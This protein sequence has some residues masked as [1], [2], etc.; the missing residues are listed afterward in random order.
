MEFNRKVIKT[1]TSIGIILPP[2][3]A[4]HLELEEG[5]EIILHPSEGKHGKYLAIW[6]KDQPSLLKVN[7]V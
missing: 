3:L 6:R 1:G 4:K 7:N 2:D 5:T